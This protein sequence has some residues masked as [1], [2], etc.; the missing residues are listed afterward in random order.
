MGDN[1]IV[2]KSKL[3][4]KGVFAKTAIKK[5]ETIFIWKPRVINKLDLDRLPKSEKNFICKVKEK[6][7]YM[8]APEKFVNHSCD[9]NTK[10]EGYSDIAIRD[11][12]AG[13][14]ITTDYQSYGI[15]AFKCNCGTKNCRGLIN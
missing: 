15:V 6:Y 2:N 11:I 13:E 12:A 8:Q 3:S 4:G 7:I 1:Y 10:T 14:E 9:S 5:G